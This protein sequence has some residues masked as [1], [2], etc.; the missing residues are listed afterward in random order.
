MHNREHYRE[1]FE[2]ARK[3][4]LDSEIDRKRSSVSEILDIKH[5]LDSKK[6][7]EDT[8]RR[9][10]TPQEKPASM[11]KLLFGMLYHASNRWRMRNTIGNREKLDELKTHLEDF[12]PLNSVKNR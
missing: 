7:D 10:L 6:I 1:I 2:M 4:I 3:H 12:N 9:Y 8:L 11:S 5:I